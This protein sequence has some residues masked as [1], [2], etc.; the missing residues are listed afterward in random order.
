MEEWHQ[1]WHFQ[2]HYGWER[3]V[4]VEVEARREGIVVIGIDDFLGLLRFSI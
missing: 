3:G 4:K 2:W 1:K